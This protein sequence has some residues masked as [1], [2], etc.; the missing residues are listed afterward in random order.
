MVVE[1]QAQLLSQER[2]LDSQKGAIITW[3][4]G[5]MASER[6]LCRACREHTQTEVVLHDYLARSRALTS[7]SKHSIN[8]N[9]MLEERQI[10][11]SL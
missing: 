5:L 9:M 2:E 6:T 11:L 8:F 7:S 4:D 10:L 3:E 1:L